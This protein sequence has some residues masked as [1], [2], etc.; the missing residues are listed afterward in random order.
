MGNADKHYFSW[1]EEELL[2]EIQRGD[3]AAFNEVYNRFAAKLY[4]FSQK[5]ELDTADREDII[6]EV[7]SAL[8]V[9][10]EVLQIDNLGAWLYMSVR[11]QAL[12]Q[13]RKK[14]YR[15]NH[16]QSI[17]NFVTP[18]Y[19]P[20]LGQIQE[21]ELQQ[22]LDR[23]LE[24]L[25]PRA[26]EVFRLSRQE[27]LTYKEIAEQLGISEKTVRKQVQNVLKIFRYKLGHKTI[28]GLV[29]IAYLY[30]KK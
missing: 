3:Y 4:S 28:E 12:Y 25:P 14:K 16:I 27:H 20:I 13:L 7:F 30:E 23:Q 8:W 19:D 5:I 2:S 9:R 26:R 22:F 24:K 1:S 15:D 21:K 11:K 17:I 18:F 6:Q 10:R 29:I